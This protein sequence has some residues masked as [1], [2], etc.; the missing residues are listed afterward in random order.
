MQYIFLSHDVDWRKQ[1]P[2]LEHIL[3]R[4]DRFEPKLFEK[5][6]P[7]DLYY[8][9]PE[10]MEIEEKFDIRST[11]FFRTFYE[12]GDVLDYE[13][14]IKQLHKSN[15][16][17]GLHTDPSSIDDLDKIR[18][19]KEKLERITGNQIIGNRVHFLN[20]NPELLN[21]LEKLGFN[22]DSSLRNSKDRI[23]EKE[24]GYSKIHGIIEFPVTLMDAYLFTYMK[25]QEDKIIS[26]FQKTLD[27][28][29]S[30]SENNV[31]SVIWH[32]N[33]LKMKGGRMYKQILEFLT[34][35]DD[36]EIK[37]GIDLVKILK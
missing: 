5:T 4:R 23:D 21:K 22:Y 27:L 7:E 9:I 3:S 18:L 13:D 16:E 37:R 34:S 33:V 25:I 1:G 17:I 30:L 6:K 32:E 8:N 19:E 12:N 35:Q 10:Y 28:G 29:R 2:T 15:W 11:F 36:V 20:Y 24:M 31:I 26:E 14:D